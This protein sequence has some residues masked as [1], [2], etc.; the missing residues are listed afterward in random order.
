[1]STISNNNIAEAI[2][3]LSKDASPSEQKNISEKVVAFLF[4]KRMLSKSSDILSRLSNIVNKAESRVVTQVTSVELISHTTSLHLTH[5][6]KERY[7]AEEVV[8][9]EKL[10]KTILGGVR[11]E[12]NN[13]VIDLTIKNQ[14]DQL[15]AHLTKDYA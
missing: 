1:M 13:E 8:L 7:K 14:I 3:L 2:Y 9:E 4:K 12:V 6:L 5:F 15:Q 10:D 11:I